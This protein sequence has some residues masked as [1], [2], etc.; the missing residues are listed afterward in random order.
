MYRFKSYL[1][2]AQ[3]II[4]SYKGQEPLPVFLKRFFSAGKKYG[5]RDRKQIT[6]LC[7]N[8]YRL[9]K[10]AVNT[11]IEERIIIGTFLCENTSNE[12]L[13]FF[14]PHWDALIHEPLENKISIAKLKINPEDIFPFLN[15]LSK[16][17][18][19]VLFC[20]SFLIQPDLFL[21]IRISRSASLFEK[22]N[23]LKIPY[24]LIGT[25]CIALPNGT[26]IE[27]VLDIDR[28]VVIQDYSSQQVFNYLKDEK[29]LEPLSHL[30]H[31]EVARNG[32]VY[33]VWDC[34]AASGGKSILLFDILKRKVDI[35][36]S[37]IRLNVLINLHQRFKKAGI[38]RYN[39]FLSDLCADELPVDSPKY[40]IILCD[41]PCTGS[42]TWSRTPE[43]LYF[44]NKETIAEY[45]SKQKKIVSNTVKF[46]QKDG[47]FI[48]STCSVFKAENES[49]VDYIQ[50]LHLQL[51]HME[52]IKGYDK[53]SRYYV[54][55]RF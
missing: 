8:F 36:V 52:L 38:K 43:Q 54:C 12:W 29:V 17:I 40:S 7:F 55:S 20:E 15:V 47:L 41:V 45:S 32:Y 24:N 39:Y 37:D 27:D 34:C 3:V 51:L 4:E 19:P 22:I 33:N 35:T 2:T 10:A 13:K 25:D 1:N 14:K 5:S 50:K 30:M 31:F 46:L 53:K 23:K 21:R 42:G 9:G 11:S 49:I 16:E 6:S 18:S 48:Y 28:E 26:K 44:F